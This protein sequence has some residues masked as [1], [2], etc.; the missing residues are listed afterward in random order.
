MK[1]INARRS[2]FWF[3]C[4]DYPC[5]RLNPAADRADK[6]P[7]NL[8]VYN[9]SYIQHQGLEKFAEH[10]PEFKD[11]YFRGKMMIGKGPHI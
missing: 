4:A 11:K 10:A 6:L 9:L 5:A 2:E 1:P 8:K 3:E 7:H